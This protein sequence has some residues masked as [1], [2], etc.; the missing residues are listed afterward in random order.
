MHAL[1]YLQYYLARNNLYIFFFSPIN[2]EGSE[3][4]VSHDRL[5]NLIL[6]KKVTTNLVPIL[7][8]VG[9]LPDSGKTTALHDLFKENNLSEALTKTPMFAA[10]NF[11]GISWYELVACGRDDANEVRYASIK[12][13][14]CYLYAVYSVLHHRYRLRGQTMRIHEPNVC[15][16]TLFDDDLLDLSFKSLFERLEKIQRGEINLEDSRFF[17]QNLPNGVA[18]IN[19]WNVGL[20]KTVFY[21]LPFLSGQ[22]SNNYLWL[23]F[24][25]DRDIEKMHLRPDIP[26]DHHDHEILMLWRSRL[27]YL[28]RHVYFTTGMKKSENVRCSIFSKAIDENCDK[29]KLIEQFK[30]KMMA[31]AKEMKI[32]H[33]IDPNEI[34][35]V[36]S[37]ISRSK[38]LKQIADKIVTE[39]FKS[40]YRVRLSWIF[41]RDAFYEREGLYVPMEEIKQKA[42]KLNIKD[43][44]FI[45]FCTFFSSFGSIID[46]SQLG[47]QSPY[48]ITKPMC[49]FAKLDELFYYVK[50]ISIRKFGLLAFQVAE[51]IFGDD[52]KFFMDVLVSANLA[53]KVKKDQ[54]CLPPSLCASEPLFYI[55]IASQCASFRECKHSTLHLQITGQVLCRN[56]QVK[57]AEQFLTLHP[58]AKINF[59]LEQNYTNC[60]YYVCTTGKFRIVCHGNETEFIMQDDDCTLGRPEFQK[61]V[62]DS[63]YN[64]L[65]HLIESE[66]VLN[67]NFSFLCSEDSLTS[68]YQFNKKRHF[69]PLKDDGVCEKCKNMLTTNKVMEI[70]NDILKKVGK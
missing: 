49:F 33:L 28:L 12:I 27:Y 60:T 17:R 52:V 23:F 39:G 16:N 59:S 56:I 45:R 44:A 4:L 10:R 29:K 1:H 14:T 35:I 26:K 65:T 42:A 5:R 15:H 43:K 68:E 18:L 47:P 67:F 9:G 51:K 38:L 6:N 62:I 22:L 30:E 58:S 69:L 37:C 3:V 36:S 7:L 19:V 41:L 61:A 11:P 53:F 8:T 54:L 46:A 31:S 64:I 32:E 66:T 57:F 70:W 50:D 48:I 63:C 34:H 2:I 21:F 55:P 24:D 25:H 13:D 40:P 20:S